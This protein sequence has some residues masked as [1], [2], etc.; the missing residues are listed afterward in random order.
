MDA[1]QAAL[2][3]AKALK[4]SAV[5]RRGLISLSYHVPYVVPLKF[6]GSRS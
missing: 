3:R 2:A 4:T 5:L 1:V 6:I